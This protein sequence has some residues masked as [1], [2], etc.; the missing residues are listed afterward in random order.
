MHT[1]K[2]PRPIALSGVDAEMTSAAVPPEPAYSIPATAEILRVFEYTVRRL[3][4]TGALRI[5][6]VSARRRIV[7]PPDLRAFP[8]SRQDTSRA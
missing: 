5:I 2:R 3:G 4:A 8:A 7:R 1:I 6:R